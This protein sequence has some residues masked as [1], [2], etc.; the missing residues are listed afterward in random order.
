MPSREVNDYMEVNAYLTRASA[1]RVHAG[2]WYLCFN[3][4]KK[5][6]MATRKVNA[7]TE[8]NAYPASTCWGLDF[9]IMPNKS[10]CLARK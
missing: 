6:H 2:A 5:E 3:Y 1:R 7:C 9:L 8:V 10:T 4:D